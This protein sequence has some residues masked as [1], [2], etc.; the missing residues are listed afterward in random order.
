MS[1]FKK[2]KKKDERQ[3][4]KPPPTQAEAASQLTEIKP[5]PS[6]QVVEQVGII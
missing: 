5:R 2:R 3:A 6:A 1:F 4:P